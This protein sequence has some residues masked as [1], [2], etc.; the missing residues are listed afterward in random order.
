MHDL[1]Y[2]PVYEKFISSEVFNLNTGWRLIL[3]FVVPIIIILI[4]GSVI[5]SMFAK[6]KKS[7]IFSLFGGNHFQKHMIGR[8]PKAKV[9]KSK[10]INK[11][12]NQ[13]QQ[14]G[15]DQ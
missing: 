11:R 10:E 15:G 4:T 2:V 12:K 8:K 13:E 7:V 3:A 9:K 6:Q 5:W 1:D 14:N